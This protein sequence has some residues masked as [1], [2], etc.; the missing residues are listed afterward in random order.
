MGLFLGLC[1]FAAGE[2]AP[3]PWG[4][5]AF[6]TLVGVQALVGGWIVWRRL[7]LR[8]VAG[9]GVAIIMFS[10]AMALY[11]WRGYTPKTIIA[12]EPWPIL[13]LMLVAILMQPL[14][15]WAESLVDSPGW[16][17]WKRRMDEQPS[18]WEMLT[19]RHV[20]NLR[21]G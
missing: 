13:V 15:I 14:S 8:H 6:W 9:A 19:F 12:H 16:Q 20:P 2:L 4:L 1:M 18:I 5:I 11:S 21:D 10:A 17:A 7:R 3:Q